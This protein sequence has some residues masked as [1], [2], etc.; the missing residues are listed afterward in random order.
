M[1]MLARARLHVGRPVDV[2]LYQGERL[3]GQTREAESCERS[4]GASAIDEPREEDLST[5]RG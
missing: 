2:G 1:A 4:G 5:G 3:L